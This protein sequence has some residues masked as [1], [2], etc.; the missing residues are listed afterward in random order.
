MV[1][2]AENYKMIG[3]GV[4][5]IIIGFTVM[6]LENEVYGI[7]SLYITP[8]IILAGYA[9]VLFAILR[10]PSGGDESTQQGSAGPASSRS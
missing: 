6:R 1:F 2:S 10:K 4:L 5:L 9:I 7:L 8:P 3:L